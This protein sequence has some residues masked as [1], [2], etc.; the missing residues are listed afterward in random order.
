MTQDVNQFVTFYTEHA[1]DAT[2]MSYGIDF[3]IILILNS[4]FTIMVVKVHWNWHNSEAKYR[5]N[6]MS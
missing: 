5:R 3:G 2:C 4:K 6:L 1:I